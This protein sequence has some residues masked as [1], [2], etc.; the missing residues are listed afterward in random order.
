MPAGRRLWVLLQ[1]SDVGPRGERVQGKQDAP[2]AVDGQSDAA[3]PDDVHHQAGFSLRGA[4]CSTTAGYHCGSCFSHTD[5]GG[6]LTMSDTLSK[7][8]EKTMALGGVA[9]GSMKAKEALS[10]QGI[11]TYSGF[12]PMDLDWTRTQNKTCFYAAPTTTTLLASCLHLQLLPGRQ[13]RAGRAL[14]WRHC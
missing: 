13:G 5:S 9:T 10:V 14:P 8:E 3:Y 2:P 1:G 6:P 4:P 11:M 12:R 7:P